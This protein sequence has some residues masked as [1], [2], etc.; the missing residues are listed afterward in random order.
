MRKT[1]NRKTR[2][3]KSKIV[4]GSGTA[5][6]GNQLQEDVKYLEIEYLDIDDNKKKIRP[7]VIDINRSMQLKLKDINIQTVLINMVPNEKLINVYISYNL[8]GSKELMHTKIH[9]FADTSTVPNK[10]VDRDRTI[11]SCKYTS[12]REEGERLAREQRDRLAIEERDREAIRVAKEREAERLKHE[13]REAERLQ[14][15]KNK[16]VESRMYSS[17][18]PG[19]P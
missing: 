5:H 3:R 1:R 9:G 18:P 2:N 10:V 13:Q 6:N 19:N 12:E 8:L 16:G 14:L 11:I 15:L 4:G 17:D 7:D